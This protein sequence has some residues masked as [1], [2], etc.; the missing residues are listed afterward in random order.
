MNAVSIPGSEELEVLS[1]SCIE[2]VQFELG[3]VKGARRSEIRTYENGR[4]S[5]T[6]C[7]I[8]C[9]W[10]KVYSEDAVIIWLDC[11]WNHWICGIIAASGNILN[12]NYMQIGS[13]L[14]VMS[15]IDQWRRAC[16]SI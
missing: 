14:F 9:L 11:S 2:I 12:C 10:P 3:L 4:S 16:C 1:P 13:A 15:P 7:S 5:P 6:C 8:K